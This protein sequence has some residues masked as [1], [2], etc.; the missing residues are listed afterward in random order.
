M[1][2]QQMREHWDEYRDGQLHILQRE[3][4]EN[5]LAG[6]ATCAAAWQRESDLLA[7]LARHDTLSPRQSHLMTLSVLN[8][9]TQ[10]QHAAR[11]HH[12]RL[13]RFVA[14]SSIAAL[15][16]VALMLSS[17]KKNHVHRGN[18]KTD[19]LAM[20]IEQWPQK[21]PLQPFQLLH[22]INIDTRAIAKWN[23]NVERLNLNIPDPAQFMEPRTNAV[24]AT[25]QAPQI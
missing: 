5:H 1:N 22:G 21:N 25:N 11:V 23:T 4:F 18:I 13:F 19:P 3:S 24:P 15:V 16:L 9:W 2:C 12:L 20:V 6:C 17:H 10:S 8:D 7:E 14:W